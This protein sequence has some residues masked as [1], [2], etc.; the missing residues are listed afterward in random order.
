MKRLLWVFAFSLMGAVSSFGQVY[1]STICATYQ[2]SGSGGYVYWRYSYDNVTWYAYGGTSVAAG[3]SV[4]ASGGSCAAAN[5]PWWAYWR[6]EW[7][8]DSGATFGGTNTSPSKI[9]SGESFTFN[10]GAPATYWTNTTA[11]ICLTNLPS[12]GLLSLGP[13]HVYACTN[14]GSPFH[15]YGPEWVDYNSRKCWSF[16]LTAT[17]SD[18]LTCFYADYWLGEV[19]YRTNGTINSSSGTEPGASGAD[20][21]GSGGGKATDEYDGGTNSTVNDEAIIRALDELRRTMSTRASESNQVAANTLLSVISGKLDQLTNSSSGLDTNSAREMTLRGVTNALNDGFGRLQSTANSNAAQAHGDFVALTNML[22]DTNLPGQSKWDSLRSA[23]VGLFGIGE[24]ATNGGAAWTAGSNALGG[25]ALGKFDQAVS[26][27]GSAP[28]IGSGTAGGLSMAFMGQTLDFNPDSSVLSGILTIVYDG[29]TF[30]LVATFALW[31]GKYLNETV[32]TLAATSSGGVP[33]LEGQ[34]SGFTFGVGGNLVG[35]LIYG[36]VALAACVLFVV[37]TN[38]LFGQLLGQLGLAAS[39]A[40]AFALGGNATALWLLNQAFPIA[41]FLSLLFL[42]V[43]L[44]I[45]GAK[46]LLAVAAAFRWLMGK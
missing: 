28:T 6:G 37:V 30:V 29:W 33:N 22:G 39:A 10:F 44:Q 41:L 46:I 7:S 34:I 18:R 3:G 9:N 36:A 17:N 45:T 21:S 40:D 31:A 2:G 19:L 11:S 20:R 24:S 43:T 1:N 16:S 38:W 12:Y 5:Y 27:V 23:M 26:E 8:T 4:K 15:V 14:N 13:V 32:R 25:T 35:V 42:R